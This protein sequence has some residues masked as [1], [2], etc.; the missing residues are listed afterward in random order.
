MKRNI[1]VQWN[2]CLSCDYKK[3]QTSDLNRHIKSM[4]APK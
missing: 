1:G 3:K 2:I 4:H